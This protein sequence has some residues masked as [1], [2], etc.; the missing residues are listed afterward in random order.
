MSIIL[1]IETSTEVCSVALSENDKL[2]FL[3][4]N[5]IANMH[6]TALTILIQDTLKATQIDIKKIAAI[7]VSQG[8]GSYTGL[9]IGVSTA[10]GLAYGLNIPLI[11]VNPMHALT[12][13]AIQ[14]IDYE[15]YSNDLFI[16]MLDARRME[17]YSAIYDKDFNEI[18]PVQADILTP[19]SFGNLLQ[20]R[21]CFFFG[22]GAG[23]F[24]EL[25]K[26]DNAYFIDNIYTSSANMCRF[27]YQHF[28][29]KNFVD[30]AYFEPF[31]LKDF[32]ATISNKQLLNLNR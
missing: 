1:N 6:A 3:K 15:L 17:V 27:A 8:P 23:K 20:S 29:Q 28:V 4:E 21:R 11:A 16:P 14:T 5:L 2:I 9:R 25:L 30:V 24:M 26:N 7:A 22:N 12:H 18:Q 13:G 31:Y 19:D 10:K 32:V